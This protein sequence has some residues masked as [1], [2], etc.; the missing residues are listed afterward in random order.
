MEREN[1]IYEPPEVME[2][3][4][5]AELT[6]GSRDGTFYEGGLRAWYVRP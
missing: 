3:G 1:E 5:F 6:L 2:V 4:E